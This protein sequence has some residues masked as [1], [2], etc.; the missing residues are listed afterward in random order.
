MDSAFVLD[1]TKSDP[2]KT[3]ADKLTNNLLQI[4]KHNYQPTKCISMIAV[5]FYLF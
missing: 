5:I 4:Y 2:T 3:K 1:R